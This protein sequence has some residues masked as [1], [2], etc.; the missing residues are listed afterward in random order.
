MI[1]S[2]PIG[3]AKK[4]MSNRS[5]CRASLCE[6]AVCACSSSALVPD[7]LATVGAG[8]TVVGRAKNG[9][10]SSSGCS[11][12]L[13]E[14]AVC[15][16]PSS[17]LVPFELTTNGIGGR[18]IE[19]AKKGSSKRSGCV[20]SP[21]AVEGC[22]NPSSARVPDRPAATASTMKH[23]HSIVRALFGVKTNMT[24]A[25]GML[26]TTSYFTRGAKEF[27]A[28]RYDLELKDYEG[29]LEWINEYRPNPNGR[30]YLRD[31]RLIVPGEE[32]GE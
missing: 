5:D 4:G 14:V 24:V 7:P 20:P 29:I 23:W 22:V 30:L 19:L 15:V 9:I 2:M 11:P 32:D 26:A 28:S 3:R 12:S 27:K 18:S 25:G 16:F 31:N 6:V 21:C 17:A 8:A 1:E 10:S 13:G